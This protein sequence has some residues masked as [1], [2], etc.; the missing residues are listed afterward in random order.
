MTV[1]HVTCCYNIIFQSSE[2]N[3]FEVTYM[4]T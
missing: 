3:L 4:E 1:S 2:N